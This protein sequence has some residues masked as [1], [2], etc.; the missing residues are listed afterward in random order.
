VGVIA[1]AIGK[2]TAEWLDAVITRDGTAATPIVISF[3][4]LLAHKV[5]TFQHTLEAQRA[6]QSKKIT[7]SQ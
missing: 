1:V 5:E 6:A 7:H 2:V 3:E 4:R